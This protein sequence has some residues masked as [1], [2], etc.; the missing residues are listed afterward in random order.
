MPDC[1]FT[2]PLKDK[3]TSYDSPSDEDSVDSKV[4]AQPKLE[5]N[6]ALLA[7]DSTDVSS[8]AGRDELGFS[9]V[10]IGGTDEEYHETMRTSVHIGTRPGT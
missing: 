3:M 4:A 2:S 10:D 9:M 1:E 8:D 6:Q 5:N 7:L